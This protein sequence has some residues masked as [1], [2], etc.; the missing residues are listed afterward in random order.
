MVYETIIHNLGAHAQA[1]KTKK[2]Q[3]QQDINAAQFEQR[4][5]DELKKYC[6]VASQVS[7]LNQT[8]QIDAILD[9][10][11]KI[12]QVTTEAE[13]LKINADVYASLVAGKAN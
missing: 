2:V 5:K 11:E 10:R 12:T 8:G 7:E 3:S 6:T 1:K 4:Q 9:N 13:K